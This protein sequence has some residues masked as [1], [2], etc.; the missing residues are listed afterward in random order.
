[1]TAEVASSRLGRDSVARVLADA[2]TVLVGLVAGVVTARTL[3]PAGKG[4]YATLSFLADTAGGCAAIGLGEV[5]VVMIARQGRR[6]QDVLSSAVA[7]S[8]LTSLV[9]AGLF[10]ALPPLFMDADGIVPAVLFGAVTIA[11]V[12]VMTPIAGV[13]VAS[14]RVV[15]ACV[16]SAVGPIV[17]TIA[18]IVLLAVADLGLPAAMS[19]G[20][21]G[22]LASLLVFGTRL[23]K[24][25]VSARPAFAGTA[26]RDMAR[27]GVAIQAGVMLQA[28]SARVDLLMIY[29]LETGADAGQY[30]IALTFA[31]MVAAIPRAI[32]Y[33]AFA[34]LSRHEPDDSRALLIRS[35]RV[36]LACAVVL[37]LV[38]AAAAPVVVPAVFGEEFRPAVKPVLVILVGGLL[39]GVQWS[40]ARGRA[41]QGESR[42]LVLSFAAST[43]TMLL[44][45]LVLIPPFGVVGAAIAAG[46][47][48]AVGCAVCL[49]PT[50]G[51]GRIRIS[52]LIPRRADL[53]VVL[54]AA[55]R[56]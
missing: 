13:V 40:I 5:V 8:L 15:Q 47:G 19:A 31:M 44:F 20:A 3:G 54:R 52:E 42:A 30:S 2:T 21:V 45:D 43:V 51:I 26:L 16:A 55:K 17:T 29:W 49:R 39:A 28:L 12:A 11:C 25:G 53:A 1:V 4:T 56:P 27:F 18:I 14:G 7:L 37:A 35:T 23:P 41:A 48:P 34:R 6:V 9:V 32:A 33:A 10:V 36:A 24:I 46:I 22:A 50:T 38:L